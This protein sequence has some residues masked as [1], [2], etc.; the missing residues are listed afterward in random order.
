[1][2]ACW[3]N[4]TTVLLLLLMCF[5]P[6]ACKELMGAETSISRMFS[7]ILYIIPLS[8]LIASL[9][10]RWLFITLSAIM[11]ITSFVEMIMVLL[12]SNYLTAGN[13][14]AILT[15]NVD[16]GGGFILGTLHKI[17]YTLP[18]VLVWISAIMVYRPGYRVKKSLM[19]GVILF[20]FA[21]ILFISYQLFIRW[22][23]NITARFYIT[24]NVLERPP[25]NFWHQ[26]YNASEQLCYRRYI[27]EAEKMSFGARKEKTEGKEIYV[28]AIGESLRY[29]SLSLAGYRR[30]TTPLL[31][32]LDNLTLFSDY[33]ST[34]NLTMYSVPQ[35]VTRATPDDFLLNYKEKSIVSPFK[36]CGFKVFVIA[37]NLLGYEKHLSFG[38]DSLIA[39]A[40]NE[41]DR[42]AELVDSLADIYE[43]SFFIVHYKG[44]HGP[45]DNFRKEQ[46]I[47]HPNPV[48]D[49]A[50]WDNHEAMVNA[51]DNTVLFTDYN[52][53]NLIK[54]IDRP[55]T[56]SGLIM[57]SDHGADYD[58]GVSDHG[59]NCNPNKAEYHVPMIVWHSTL[60]AE[61]H[62]EKTEMLRLHKDKPV[63]ADCV[64]Y[65]VCDMAD[66]VLHPS[67]G[68]PEWSVFS[69][70]FIPHKRKLLVPDGKN[71][72]TLD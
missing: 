10:K 64:L 67:Y 71:V 66:I 15:T 3:R 34:A 36:E 47:F 30:S 27:T 18:L 37:A 46:D 24:Q 68:K 11:M 8:C 20:L 17:P 2:S 62:K 9:H 72:I 59:G 5:M 49:K 13:L 70:T 31:E 61:H 44:N 4:I 57:V 63:N 25:Y 28:L 6:V 12:Y 50:S 33:Y 16:E 1:M 7:S 35:I 48:S 65:S 60:W 52:T 39:L 43:K 40:E 19:G 54:A 23:N 29:S 32:S 56:Q 14:L 55:E 69:K 53:Y 41:D 51:Y 42:I 26:F 58:T 22:D 38:C 21:S 45:Y